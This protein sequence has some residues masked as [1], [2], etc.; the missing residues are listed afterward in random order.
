MQKQRRIIIRYSLVTGVLLLFAAGP[1]IMFFNGE[2]DI[3]RDWRTAERISAGLAPD[4]I[5]TPE[6]VVQ[7]YAARA[8]KWRGIFAVHTWITTKP[9]N[10]D[11]FTVHHALGWNEGRGL[12][13]VVSRRDIPD[14]LWYGNKPVLVKELRGDKAAQAII[15]I[16]QAINNYPYIND[17]TAWPGPNSNTFIAHIGRHV[18]AL[19]LDLPST[20]IGK[21]FLSN[22]DFISRTP[23]GTG[24]QLSLFGLFGILISRYEGFEVNLLGLVVGLDPAEGIIKLPGIGRIGFGV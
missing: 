11:H 21:D 17:Y 3:Y 6:A 2:V 18:S 12:P 7:V 15:A 24:F 14:R 22:S 5:S 4:P 16:E 9:E 19:K 8:V 20:A 1:A 13:V 23:S 10:A